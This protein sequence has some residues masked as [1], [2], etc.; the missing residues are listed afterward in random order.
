M[1]LKKYKKRRKPIVS[2]VLF[3]PV[4]RPLG[5]ELQQRY[6]GLP[7]LF[8]LDVA[9]NLDLLT[10]WYGVGLIVARLVPSMPHK[11]SNNLVVF[12]FIL[13]F[14]FLSFLFLRNHKD[15][16]AFAVIYITIASILFC[17]FSILC[18]RSVA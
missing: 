17:P 3:F 2:L 8:V 1:T 11:R 7:F 18:E 9:C 5:I 6:F 14:C 12:I 10:C 16:V 15:F 13:Q 4:Y